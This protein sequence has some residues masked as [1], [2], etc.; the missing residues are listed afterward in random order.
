MIV[1][2]DSDFFEKI[3]RKEI[4]RYFKECYNFIFNYKN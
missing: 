3:R 1:T 2:F 4:E